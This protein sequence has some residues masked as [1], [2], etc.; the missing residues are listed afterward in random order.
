MID[1][2]CY[3]YGKIISRVKVTSKFLL[4]WI[5][6]S[7]QVKAHA[8]ENGSSSMAYLANTMREVIKS[9]HGFMAAPASSSG[10]KRGK[11]S[12]PVVVVQFLPSRSGE[13]TLRV[14]L[15]VPADGPIAPF[16]SLELDHA[17]DAVHEEVLFGAVV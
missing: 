6:Y 3:L 12:C 7:G 5:S 16:S 1:L 9:A 17:D 13:G 15:A 2:K 8:D 11:G 4:Q 10:C 14:R